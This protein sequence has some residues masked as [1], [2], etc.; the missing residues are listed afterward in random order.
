MEDV[1]VDNGRDLAF[2]HPGLQL[3]HGG[4]PGRDRQGRSRLQAF[5]L[6]PRL[7]AAKPGADIPRAHQPLPVR[8]AVQVLL[9]EQIHTVGEAV[10]GGVVD[11]EIDTDAARIGRGHDLTEDIPGA[12][13]IGMDFREAAATLEILL[14]EITH[15][16]HGVA[17]TRVQ[18]KRLPGDINTDDD[19]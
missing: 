13:G 10:A 6:L 19:R 4:I 7:A 14:I 11:G 1:F 5:G 9:Q 18:E 12:L 17:A 3:G 16:R 2:G 8:G 15:Q